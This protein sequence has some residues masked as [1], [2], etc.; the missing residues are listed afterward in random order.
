MFKRVSTVCLV[1]MLL[2][3]CIP[4]THALEIEPYAVVNVSGGLRS[5]SGGK[6]VLWGLAEG[7]YE[8]KTI[9][10]TLYRLE[11]GKYK[12]YTSAPTV[13]DTDISVET[14]KTVSVPTGYQYKVEA[15][16]TT[17][18]SSTTMPYYYDFR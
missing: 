14:C 6:Y 7:A 2:L 17:S 1:L 3:T 12:E 9:K 15:V 4:V 11:G 18:N 10:V 16:G 8:Y 13:S 5:A